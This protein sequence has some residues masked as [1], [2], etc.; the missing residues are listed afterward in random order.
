MRSCRSSSVIGFSPLAFDP[1]YGQQTLAEVHEFMVLTNQMR[2]ENS[3]I[4]VE[5]VGVAN[6][7]GL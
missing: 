4:D 7:Q 2:E 6:G 1:K 5:P 3:V